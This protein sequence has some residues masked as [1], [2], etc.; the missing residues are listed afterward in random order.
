MPLLRGLARTAAIA[1]TATAVSNRVSRRQSRR[2]DQKE[3]SQSY[4]QAQAAPQPP[5]DTG[6]QLDELQKLGDLHQQGVLTDQE[7]T[8]AK[9]QILNG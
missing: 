7:F 2:W 9:R 8:A 6:S 1:G 3:Q 5:V 4:G